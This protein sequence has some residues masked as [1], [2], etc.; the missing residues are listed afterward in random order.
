MTLLESIRE[1]ARE[2]DQCLVFPEGNDSRVL[3]A[4]RELADEKIVRPVLLGDRSEVSDL[5]DQMDISTTGLEILAPSKSSTIDELAQIFFER[6]KH[7]GIT[8]EDAQKQV[9]DPLY[10]GALMVAS[11]LCDGYVA[12]ATHT[13]GDTVRAGITCIGLKP[14]ISVVSSFFMMVHPDKNWGED[15][16]LLYADGAVV[17]DPTA[18]ELADIA[19]STAENTRIY[20]RTEPRVALLSFSTRGSA[21]HPLVEKV[22]AAVEITK[23]RNP[24]LLVDGELQVDAALLPSIAAKKAPDSCL[25]GRANTLVFPNL[26]AGNIAYKLTQRLGGAQAIGPI[27]QGLKKPLNDLSRGCSSEDVI[28]VAAITALQAAEVKK[29][30]KSYVQD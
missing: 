2:E 28:N 29:E 19:A 18:E 16:A 11:G 15:G 13:T 24:D 23:K 14:G 26:D 30:A 25:E 1:R 20:L 27:L 9:L 12:G 4:A 3:Q 21:S 7:K 17:P 8:F 5:A 22:A 10:Y 6:R